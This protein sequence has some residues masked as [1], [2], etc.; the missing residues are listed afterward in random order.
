MIWLTLLLLFSLVATTWIGFRFLNH[1]RLITGTPTS[2]IRSAH[3]GYVEVI[4]HIQDGEGDILRAPLSNMECVWYRFKVEDL[5]EKKTGPVNSGE[6]QQWF[7]VSDSSGTCL[8]DPNGARVKPDYTRTWH[9][10]TLNPRDETYHHTN[11]TSRSLLTKE[12]SGP[13]YRYTE[14]LLMRHEKVYL[15]GQFRSVGG[16]RHVESVKDL[17]KEVITE[18]KANYTALLERFDENGD[19]KID[20]TEWDAVQKAAAVEANERRRSQ[21]NSPSMHVM[22]APNN[23]AQP[24][25][26]STLNEE[27]LARRYGLYSLGCLVAITAEIYGLLY[28][29]Y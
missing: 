16:G 10:N 13:R 1:Y 25:L 22:I 24:Y 17:T 27:T 7:Q 2:L 26:I 11:T 18:W 15:L 19:N 14:S 28:L 4:G 8:V 29:W 20:M 21:I 6:S 9:G 3:Q 5:H 23:P 12:L